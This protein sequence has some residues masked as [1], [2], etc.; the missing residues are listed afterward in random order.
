MD[1]T[2]RTV[3][4]WCHDHY[5]AGELRPAATNITITKEQVGFTPVWLC[6]ACM[7]RY[8]QQETERIASARP[9]SGHYPFSIAFVDGEWVLS[10]SG[11]R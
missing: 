5:A 2:D 6:A 3:C 8:D 1:Q 9:G 4:E 11:P 7:A 10:Y